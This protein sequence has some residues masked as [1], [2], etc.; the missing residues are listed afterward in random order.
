MSIGKSPT[1]HVHGRARGL[2][3]EYWHPTHVADPSSHSNNLI[4][5][6]LSFAWTHTISPFRITPSKHGVTN[7][8]TVFTFPHFNG[9]WKQ[10]DFL[11]V[12]KGVYL[13]TSGGCQAHHAMT[14]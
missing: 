9:A 4:R 13:S 1:I 8:K 6:H 7:L 2:G 12:S 5:P 14:P 10:V 11:P 3:W